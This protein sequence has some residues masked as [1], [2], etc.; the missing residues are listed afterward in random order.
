MGFFKRLFSIGSKKN[1]NKNKR[2]ITPN[3]E[4]IT[5][6]VNDEDHEAA[7]GKILRSSSAR[8]AETSELVYA[9]LPPIRKLASFVHIRLT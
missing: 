2:S 6:A 4:Q 8:F 3:I 5:P 9:A 7:I 1:K